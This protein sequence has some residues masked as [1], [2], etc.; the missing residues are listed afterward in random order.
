MPMEMGKDDCE[1][2]EGDDEMRQEETME[3]VTPF[4]SPAS[5]GGKA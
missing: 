1:H 5:S 4:P 2:P 3:G